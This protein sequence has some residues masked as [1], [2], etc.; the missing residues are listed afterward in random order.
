MRR[1]TPAALLRVLESLCLLFIVVAG[2]QNL[3]AYEVD[4]TG[5]SAHIDPG[6]QQSNGGIYLDSNGKYVLNPGLAG[7]V[8]LQEYDS[9][10]VGVS[11]LWQFGG[12]VDCRLWPMMFTGPLF[13]LS[14]HL[15]KHWS[16]DLNL[17]LS[18]MG[19]LNWRALFESGAFQPLLYP[20][21]RYR[22]DD[23]SGSFNLAFTPRNSALFP[24]AGSNLLFLFGSYISEPLK[25]KK[26]RVALVGKQ[27]QMILKQTLE[28]AGMDIVR[29]SELSQLKEAI[30]NGL[31]PDLVFAEGLKGKAGFLGIKTESGQIIPVF[32]IETKA[33]H[34]TSGDEI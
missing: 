16:L 11:V 21:V 20:A 12:L 13:R 19:T 7:K 4:I 34:S 26:V 1:K 2:I 24:T 3:W 6:F 5:I 32:S 28:R 10:W 27:E 9:E 30:A 14:L 15:S 33:S 25:Q 18:I 8:I 22:G 31:L 17:A 23:F 29:Y